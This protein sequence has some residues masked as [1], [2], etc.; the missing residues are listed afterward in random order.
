SLRHGTLPDSAALLTD[1]GLFDVT[2]PSIPG[3]G[4]VAGL[5]DTLGRLDQDS[6][7]RVVGP[8]TARDAVVVG[9]I[10]ERQPRHLPPMREVLGEVKRRADV[11][12][13]RVTAE[14]DRRAFYE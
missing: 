3:L 2:S 13:R 6:T 1:S 10:T 14:A 7:I 11:E 8:Y 9:A 4:R 5:S 12:K